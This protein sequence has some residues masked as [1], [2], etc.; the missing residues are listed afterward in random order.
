MRTQGAG[1]TT[2]FEMYSRPDRH[3]RVRLIVDGELDIASVPP[4]RE[5][6]WRLRH[7]DA[8]V[9]LDLTAV[10]F[11]DSATIELLWSLGDRR[12]A[13]NLT[14]VPP[15]G[16]ARELLELTGIVPRFALTT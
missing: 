8:D 3:G 13:G 12:R 11:L 1:V 16:H 10:T 5:R 9:V 14:I 6:L 7:E 15:V 2:W 4:L